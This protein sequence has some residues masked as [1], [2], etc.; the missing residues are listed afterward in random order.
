MIDA[1]AQKA[2][3]VNQASSFEDVETDKG[4]IDAC[5]KGLWSCPM[6]NTSETLLNEILF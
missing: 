3:Q 6:F 4:K 5:E 2:R 1:L